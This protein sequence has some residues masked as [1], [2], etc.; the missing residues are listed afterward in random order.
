MVFKNE[1]RAF[2]SEMGFIF[3][4]AFVTALFF[5][6]IFQLEKRD[7]G[8]TLMIYCIYG[9]V[10]CLWFDEFHIQEDSFL[11][12]CFYY[13]KKIKLN[14][15]HYALYHRFSLKLYDQQN[16]II[17]TLFNDGSEKYQATLN[18]LQENKIPFKTRKSNI[19]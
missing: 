1:K 8:I 6:D 2:L 12:K 17:H 3:V 10:V 15:I 9:I 14:E 7:I 13:E 11:T 16:N 19:F 5:M 4:T 18:K